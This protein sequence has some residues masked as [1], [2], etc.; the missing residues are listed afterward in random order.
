[1]PI[2]VKSSTK[3][4]MQS[5]FQFMAEKQKT[6]GIRCSLEN[7]GTYQNIKVIPLYGISMIGK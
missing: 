4:S 7:F 2:E 1:V 3:G 5:M 6:Y